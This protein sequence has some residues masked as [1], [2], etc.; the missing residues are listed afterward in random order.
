[1]LFFFKFNFALW[2]LSQ[3]RLSGRPKPSEG[4]ERWLN[5]LDNV[6]RVAV[7]TESGTER[8]VVCVVDDDEDEQEKVRN[9]WDFLDWTTP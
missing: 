7:H 4:S 5:A 1:M 8:I 9:N 2:R 3:K 6:P